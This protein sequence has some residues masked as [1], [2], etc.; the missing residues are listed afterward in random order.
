MAKIVFGNINA[1]QLNIAN[2]NAQINAI[3]ENSEIYEDITSR[4]LEIEKMAK[5][6]KADE[7]AKKMME[8]RDDYINGVPSN[9]KILDQIKNISTMIGLANGIPALVGNLKSLMDLMS[10][11][12]K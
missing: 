4:I 5:R 1:K 9:K 2:D 6:E 7:I 3:Q 10:N 12:I 11:I 8:I